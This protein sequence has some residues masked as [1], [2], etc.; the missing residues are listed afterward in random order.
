MKKSY[1]TTTLVLFSFLLLTSVASFAQADA[2]QWAKRAGGTSWDQGHSI[3]SD[4]AGNSLVTGY[5]QGTATFGAGESNETTLT[6]AGSEDIFVAK[7]D[8]SGALL[9]AKRAGGTSNEGGYGIISDGAG[10][11]LVTGYFQGTATFGAGEANETTLISSGNHDIFVAKYDGSGTL[12]WAKSAGGTSNDDGHSIA[13]DGAGNSF[14]TGYFQGTATFGAGEA[15]ETTLTSAGGY[16]IFVAK[17]DGSGTL[18]W[19]MRAGGT[20]GAYG[21]GISCDG[22]GNSLITGYFKNTA[23]FGAGE[24]NE[25]TLTSAGSDDIFVAKYDGNGALLWAK[26][27]GG[28][29]YDDGLGIATDGSGN[30]LVTG[31]FNGTATFGA[32]ESNETT[33]TSA[34]SDDI[35]VAKYDGNG[36]LVWAKRAGG[37]D[38]DD[39]NGIATDGSGNSLVTGYFEGSATFGAGEANETT[40][41]S[42]GLDDIFIAKYDGNGTLLWAKSAGGTDYDQGRGIASDGASNSLVTGYFEG[43]AIFGAGEANETTLTSA[44]GHDIF[45]AKYGQQQS[46]AEIDVQRPAGTSIADGGTDDVGNQNI[47]TV[48]LTYTIDNTAGTAQ[49]NVTA[50]SATNLTNC[51]NFTVVTGLPL[52]VAAGGTGTL[53]IS[54]DVDAAGAFSFDMDIANNDDDENP[55]DIQV[56][57][58]GTQP[59]NIVLSSFYANISQDGILLQWTTETEPNNAGFNIFRSQ[60]EN[61]EY[62]KINE[63]LIPAQGNATTGAN[64]SY[65]DNS[66]Q[67]GSYYY[68]LQSVSLTGDTSFYGPVSVILT[69]VDNK[70]Y[71]VP[72]DYNLSQNYPNPFNPETQINYALPE[73]ATVTLNIYDINGHL[74]RTLVSGQ[75]SAG[76]HTVTWDGRDNSGVKVVSGIYFYHFKAAGAKQSFSQTNKMILMK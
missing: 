32:G 27:A 12:L 28:T 2:L 53:Q 56:T 37:T 38:Y 7:Y 15:N 21:Y 45:V 34:G 10:N 63:N 48:N 55:Y 22:A 39:G 43:S 52:H 14:V 29:D 1:L 46:A 13:S 31:M 5:F 62:A 57:G 60:S 72:D 50:V 30:S 9:W 58:N 47:G 49:L 54:F 65:P 16:D 40:L 17:Y 69:A 67:M 74:A 76:L 73:P 61:G 75:K 71:T 33:L 64:Y 35:F 3:A 23:T 8:G 18:L 70:K 19:A 44:G 42:A 51:S 11:S 6:S 36:T 26:R 41:T 66:T 20:S 59:T 68:K 4:G 25:T 24:S